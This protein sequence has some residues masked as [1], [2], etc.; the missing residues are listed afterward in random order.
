MITNNLKK[1]IFTSLLLF[2]LFFLIYYF[3]FFLIYSLIVLGVLSLIEFY[4]A[5]NKIIKSKLYT[6]FI[7]ITFSIFVSVFCYL[8]LFFSFNAQLKLI[9][10]I[11]LLGCIFSD[12]GGY[13]FGKTFGG[14]KLTNISPNKT[15]AGSVGSL[16]IS[17]TSVFVLFFIFF[18]IYSLNILFVG[19]ITSLACQMGD[20]FF[21]YLKRK[22]KFKDFGKYLPGHGGVLDRLDGIFFGVPSGLLALAILN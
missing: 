1:R 5:I 2:F 16:L 4:N 17:A 12:I 20:L 15:I 18:G 13:L 19:L 10:F 6:L 22:A 3:N 9:M 14:P 7:N 21:S 11:I 8:F